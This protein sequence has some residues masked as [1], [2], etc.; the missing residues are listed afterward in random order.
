MWMGKI[1]S[2]VLC[3]SLVPFFCQH[4]AEKLNH[5]NISS[6][7][8]TAKVIRI[9]DGDTM[10]VLYKNTPRKIR[11]AHID[12][13]ENKGAQPFGNKAKKALSDLCFGQMV[14]VHG[15]KLDRYGRLIAIVTNDQNQVINQ[16][17]I[18]RGM[19]WH[20]KKYSHDSVY[21]NL[22]IAA[23]KNRI[24]LWQEPNPSPPWEWRKPK[25]K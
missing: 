23:R 21:A 6:L 5:C 8:F 4:Q 11:L 18:K 1:I 3:L 13:P 19:A 25:R 9:M 15:E 10:E 24:G 14:T 12:C 17:M 20:F 2:F 16:E 22:E 7:I